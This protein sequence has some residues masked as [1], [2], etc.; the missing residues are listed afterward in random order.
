MQRV[1]MSVAGVL[2]IGIGLGGPAR[3]GDDLPPLNAPVTL[4]PAVDV[5]PVLP[6]PTG[7]VIVPPARPT[8]DQG[9]VLALPGVTPPRAASRTV[10]PADEMP[11]LD[12]PAGMD[13][14]AIRPAPPRPA[15][16]I[17]GGRPL[18][19][20]SVPV[21]EFNIRSV[22]PTGEIGTK[23]RSDDSLGDE[24]APVAPGRRPNLLGRGGPRPGPAGIIRPRSGRIENPVRIE[25]KKDPAADAELERKIERQAGLA[26]GKH[27]R[28]VEVRVV[29]RTVYIRAAGVRFLQR[30]GVRRSLE[31]LPG[32]SGY[33]PIIDLAD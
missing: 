4:P 18:G 33:R 17:G 20:E 31:S 5:A 24:P 25:P 32:L 3:S 2:A 22:E 1:A 11:S 23:P 9:P 8:A 30:R 21:D 28:A 14:R 13:A 29:G 26:V 19:L 15:A 27:A 16:G 7:P 6:P 12:A 10:A